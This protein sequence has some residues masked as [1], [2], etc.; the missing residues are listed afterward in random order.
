VRLN[1]YLSAMCLTSPVLV[2]SVG[3]VPPDVEP[4]PVSS[5]RQLRAVLSSAFPKDVVFIELAEDFPLDGQIHCGRIRR[6]FLDGKGH[7][8]DLGQLQL[9]R[10]TGLNALFFEHVQVLVVTDVHFVNSTDGLSTALKATGYQEPAGTLGARLDIHSC[11][12]T[13]CPES[14]CIYC[15]GF[16]DTYVTACRFVRSSI[17]ERRGKKPHCLYFTGHNLYLANCEAI[18]PGWPAFSLR[19]YE[20]HG[21][22]FVPLGDVRITNCTVIAPRDRT[23]GGFGI[24]AGLP[25]SL[26]IEHCTFIGQT[27]NPPIIVRSVLAERRPTSIDYNRYP[28]AAR[29][30]RWFSLIDEKKRLTF[31]EWQE[32]FGFDQHSTFDAVR[33]DGQSKKDEAP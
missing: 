3:A 25:R 22:P 4:V 19:G 30:G 33:D 7:R 24:S 32:R 31:A 20:G 10:K 18:E 26:R 6:V 12:W 17:G 13:D 21:S 16:E 11:S 14:N 2:Q 28:P 29:E 9:S 8:L 23:C 27:L 1:L 5:A 15:G